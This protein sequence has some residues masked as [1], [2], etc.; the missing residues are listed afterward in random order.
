M[1]AKNFQDSFQ[2]MIFEATERNKK[3][4]CLMWKTKIWPP[5]ICKW[6]YFWNVHIIQST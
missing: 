1:V 2:E 5:L 6:L 3:E 4:D